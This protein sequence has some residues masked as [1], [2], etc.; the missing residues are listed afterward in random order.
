[1][2]SK[3]ISLV[4]NGDTHQLFVQP[5]DTLLQVLRDTLGLIGTK[6]GCGNG[7]C[8]A[9]TVLMDGRPVNSCIVLAGETD[10]RSITTI[11][12]LSK[13]SQLLPLQQAFIDYGGFQCG[14]CTPGIILMARAFLDRHPSPTEAEVRQALAGN[15]CRCTG[16]DKVI[17][18][19]LAAAHGDKAPSRSSGG[20]AIGQRLPRVDAAAK[21]TGQAAFGADMRLPGMLYA[22]VLRSPH[23]HA[24]IKRLDLTK[25]LALEGVKGAVTG[26]DI[27]PL[28]PEVVAAAGNMYVNTVDHWK[29]LLARDRVLHIGQGVAVVAAT[30]PHIAEEALKLIEVE[31]EPLPVAGDVLE[32]MK[33]D[34]PLVH[35]DLLTSGTAENSDR[36]SNVASVLEMGHGDV[37]AGFRE[38]DV[39]IEETYRTQMVHQGYLEPQA[40]VASADAAACPE[41][42]EWGRVTVWTSTQGHFDARQSLCDLLSIPLSNVKVVPTEIGGGFGGKMTVWIEP[43]CVLLS[44][45]TGRPV[46]IVLTR[47]EVFQATGPGSPA[48]ITIKA[49]AAKDGKLKALA[50]KFIYDA[51][52]YPG[53]PVMAGATS[54]IGAY[55]LPNYKIECYDVVTNKPWVKAYRAPGT[56][57][58]AFAVESHM[59]AMAEALG[60]DAVEFRRRNAVAEGDPMPGDRP[61]NRIGFGLLLDKVAAHPAWTG[62]ID[63]AS[64]NKGPSI[65]PGRGMAC[66][67]WF[68]AV[69]TSSAQ[70]AL[71]GD[72]SVSVSVGTPDLTG[73]RTGL[74]QVAADTFGIP[75]GRVSIAVNDTDSGGFS[76][77]SAGS[78]TIYS[79]GTAVFRACQDA[80]AQ[81][82]GRAAARLR[83]DAEK[84]DYEKGVFKVKDSAEPGL[85]LA[86]LG[87][88]SLWR[89]DGPVVGHGSLTRMAPAPG[90]A[91]HVVDVEVDRDTGKVKLLKYT[92]FQDVGRAVNPTLVEG[93]MQGGATQGI[94]W[95][96]SEG[97]VF[98][99]GVL[100]NPSFM[101]YRMPT[102]T[103]VPFIDTEIVEAP[104]PDGPYGARGVGEVPIA[105][106][107]AA[108]ANAIYRATGV[109]LRELPMSPERVYRALRG[110]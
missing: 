32:A 101:D 6:E 94:G 35:P 92:A 44:Q 76:D 84:I 31:Y 33:P 61:Y 46:K 55:R 103:D 11:E 85:S 54:G 23:A 88:M 78:R 2:K 27:P 108:I 10:G 21:V 4:V 57:Q 52:A 96:L 74:L 83:V 67:M 109:R 47:E 28:R 91:A 16:Y 38:S 26:A 5:R 17:K 58:A 45:R 99:N 22:K 8:G 60:L 87:K 73:T 25:A 105:P 81:L 104:S 100:Q 30:G 80:I 110:K 68:G 13:G 50:G 62:E 40:A 97:Y 39:I 98:D 79:M 64:R 3:T 107:P 34:S 56:T 36:P 41:P 65:R 106:P 89:G 71:N 90:F 77:G 102:A 53:S 59:D 15:L 93:Q 20:P 49:G 12:G 37:E 42:G 14:F 86:D 9:C 72:G 66:G 51:G 18:A 69:L 43:L 29:S 82:K 1:M 48:V 75:A 24:R 70:A 63:G 7:N 19:V 95:A